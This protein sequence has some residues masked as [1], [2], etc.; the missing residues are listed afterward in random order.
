MLHKI[1]SQERRALLVLTALIVLGTI[2]L[3]VLD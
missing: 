3:F 2:G 1:T